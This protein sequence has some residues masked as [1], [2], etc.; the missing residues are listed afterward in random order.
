MWPCDDGFATAR[1]PLAKLSAFVS[2]RRVWQ[3]L[4]RGGW[5]EVQ[6]NVAHDG[7]AFWKNSPQNIG[8]KKGKAR[9]RPLSGLAPADRA[10]MRPGSEH[11]LQNWLQNGG[12]RNRLSFGAGEGNRTLDI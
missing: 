6:G 1:I 4:G 7:N 2:E 3:R 10:F 5:P 11:K 12:A 8:G 9:P